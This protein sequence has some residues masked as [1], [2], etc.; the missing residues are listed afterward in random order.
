MLAGTATREAAI[1]LA[2]HPDVARVELEQAGPSPPGDTAEPAA[3]DPQQPRPTRS[4]FDGTGQAVAV[5]DTGVDY[6]VSSLGE[7]PCLTAK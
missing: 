5:I 6:T 1:T 4:G 7:G 2:N 3:A